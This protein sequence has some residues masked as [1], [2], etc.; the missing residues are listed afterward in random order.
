MTLLDIKNLSVDFVNGRHVTHA[1]KNVSLSVDKG[2]T[3]AVVGESG[4]GKSVTALSVLQLLPYP[5]AQ[6]PSGSIKFKGEELM[7][8]RE[9]VLR[10]IR[11]NRI[12]MIFQEPMTSLNPLHSVEKQIAEVLFLHKR[13]TPAAARARVVELL[14]LVGL[15]R[16][17]HRLNAFPHELSG[18]QRQ[19]VMI[20]MALANDPDLLI[21]DEP[22]TA[23]DVTVQAQLLKLLKELQQKLGM[24]IILITH[25]LSIVKKMADHVAV[26]HN[27]EVVETAK[28]ADLFANPRHDYTKMLLAAQ[29]KGAPAPFDES[30]PPVLKAEQLKVWFPIKTGFFRRTTDYVKAVDGIDISLRSGQTIGVVGESG[31]GKTTLGLALLRLL[32]SR[33]TISFEGH[34]LSGMNEKQI[35]PL[36]KEMQIVF[37]DPYGS[38]S[39]RRSVAQ[40]IEEG[41]LVH[42]AHLSPQEREGQMIAA[43]KE[44]GLDPETRNRYP[45]EFSG[46]QRQRISIARAMVLKP[47]LVILDEPTSALD[48]SVQAQIV[49]LLKDLQR[50]HNLAYLFISHDLRVVRAM[51]HHVMVMKNGKVVESG[52]AKE[53]FENPREDYT[54]TLLAAALNIEA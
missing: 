1:V 40:I 45:H 44:V 22:T 3:L 52:P 39:P 21:A 31:S 32:Q 50:K 19:R 26:M 20:A 7:H 47:R 53:I 27:G 30:A 9:S 51:S 16:L 12:S 15:E 34:A 37:Q 38:L 49:D 8:A 28:T 29:P 18:G 10:N 46:G 33:G 35:R 43:L 6:H 4:S 42:F 25:D 5:V 2:E 41:L 36:R 24:A 11:G 17:T 48:M 54:K 13:M 23:V 14:T